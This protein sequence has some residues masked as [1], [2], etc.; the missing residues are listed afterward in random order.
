MTKMGLLF[1]I[2]VAKKVNFDETSHLFDQLLLYTN[3]H[4][5]ILLHIRVGETT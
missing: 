4:H 1:P 3:N 2:S 5:D